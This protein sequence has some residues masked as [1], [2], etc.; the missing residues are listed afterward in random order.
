MVLVH[1]AMD[2][3]AGLAHLVRQF[4]DTTTIRYDRRGYGHARDL[5]LGDL[6]SHVDD[7]VQ[8]V[9]DRPVVLFG[10][11]FGGLVVLAAAATQRLNVHAVV[12]WEVPTPWLDEWVGWDRTDVT[13]ERG[14]KDFMI[15]TIGQER[16]LALPERTRFER[17][18]EGVALRAD[19]DPR[20]KAGVPF[21]PAEIVVPCLFGSGDQGNVPYEAGAHWLAYRV[22]EGHVCVLPGLDHGAPLRNADQIAALIRR[23]KEPPRATAV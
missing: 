14:A 7:L 4:R 12:T 21:D 2:R 6:V 23:V 18:A 5:E 15:R 11:S 9:G 13:P 8:I 20:L 10:H 3:A 1:G 19:M 16:W 22:K 17:C